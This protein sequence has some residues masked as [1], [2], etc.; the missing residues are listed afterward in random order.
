MGAPRLNEKLTQRKLALNKYLCHTP[1]EIDFAMKATEARLLDFL[2][3][4]PQFVIP[5]YQ[6]TYSWDQPECRQLWD[7]ILR[8]GRDEDIRSHFIGTI[9]YIESGLYQVSSR[10]SLMVIDGQQRLTTVSL[11]IESLARELGSEEPVQGFSPRKLR[12]YYLLNP[13]EEG[14]LRYKLLLSQTDRDTLLA[15]VNQKP[16][17]ADP[18]LRLKENFEFFRKQIKMLGNKLEPLCKG[19]VKLMVVDI[20]LSRDYD[21]PQ[22]IFESMN[23]TG[24]DLSQADLIRNFVLMD[25]E[26]N[27][28]TRL[29]NDYWRPM[30]IAF[31]QETY[32]KHFDGF[33]RHY[34]TA[35]TGQIPKEGRV[36]EAFKMYASKIHAASSSIDSLVIDLH[37]FSSYYCA[38]G[39]GKEKNPDLR[40]AFADLQEL[41]A[42]VT[43]PFLLEIYDD[44]TNNLLSAEELEQAV[45]LVESYV[46]R[47]NVCDI[48]ANSMNKTFASF[49]KALNK[50]QNYLESIKAQFQLLQSYRRFPSDEE[51]DDAILSRN[52]YN[53]QRRSY[54]LRR[55]E[56]HGR[57]E[58]VFVN[59]YTIEHIMP[60][61]LTTKWQEAL[62]EDYKRIH[63]EY[64]HTLGNLTLTGYNPEY[65]DRSFIEKRDMKG[66][67]TESPLHLNEGLSQLQTWDEKAIQSRA[68]RLAEKAITVWPAPSLPEAISNAY[69]SKTPSVRDYTI[70]DYRHLESGSTIRSLFNRFRK[71]VL[72]LDSCVD[73]VFLKNYISYKAES[74]F[75][76]LIPQAKGL[77]I[78]LNLSFHELQDP[79]ELARNMS[80]FGHLGAGDVQITFS[81]LEDLPY[82]MGLVRQAFEKHM[83]DEDMLV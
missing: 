58:R 43:Y 29:Y 3:K 40:A 49:S 39:L 61:H 6:R 2:K 82:I 75:V 53:F 15:I 66:G 45:R 68:K 60:Q 17:L 37:K 46:F 5:I 10:S 32:S 38:M 71:E 64:L 22:R 74:N 69:Q 83:G 35:K 24:R 12:N 7:D 4:S 27:H 55:L 50:K 56:N 57:K 72:S 34:L 48:P 42:N 77:K 20:A 41:K 33:M 54:W 11:I 19:L 81:R 44:Y 76:D 28:Q 78:T 67:F 51:F 59:E 79:R 25:L 52:L 21:N 30:E 73:E 26:P 8:A 23:S 63:E 31:G 36:Y 62:G 9:V 16:P 14:D 1:T 13:E 65:G 47:R 18:P 80:N 70:E